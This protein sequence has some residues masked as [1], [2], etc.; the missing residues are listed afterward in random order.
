MHYD[1][2]KAPNTIEEGV[3][4]IIECILVEFLEGEEYLEYPN[5]CYVNWND[6]QKKRYI[7]SG[8]KVAKMLSQFLDLGKLFK[9]NVKEDSQVPTNLNKSMTIRDYMRAYVG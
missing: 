7:K 4:R 8:E 9:E 1:D 5:C 6:A 2:E 3:N